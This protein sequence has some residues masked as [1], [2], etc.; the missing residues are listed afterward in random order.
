MNASGAKKRR[1]GLE[2]IGDYLE[3]IRANLWD[4]A[5]DGSPMSRD[6]REALEADLLDAI[7]AALAERQRR[8]AA[9]PLP[10]NPLLRRVTVTDV[11]AAAIRT[12]RDNA[13]LTQA[14]MA[15]LMVKAG[16]VTWKRI[17]VAEVES[18]KRK[19]SIEEMMGVA[20]LFDVPVAFLMTSTLP[21]QVVMLNERH[22]LT[23]AQAQT[24]ITGVPIDESWSGVQMLPT[25]AASASLVEEGEDDWRPNGGEGALWA[26]CQEGENGERVLVPPG[27]EL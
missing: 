13:E 20:A 9:E 8:R 3:A 25:K 14:E 24:L 2:E 15:R 5:V 17:T 7:E 10:D 11:V 23:P 6:R 1:D 19:L 21:D 22:L 18:G 12:I 4:V 27:W 16:F 26:G